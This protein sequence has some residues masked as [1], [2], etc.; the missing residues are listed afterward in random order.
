VIIGNSGSGKSTL[1]HELAR[2]IGARAID[3]DHIHWQ[4]EYGSKRDEDA[5]KRI[6]AGAAAESR[7]VIEGSTAGSPKSSCRARHR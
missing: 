2:R 3:L 4:G 7:C 1:A 6:A 5:A